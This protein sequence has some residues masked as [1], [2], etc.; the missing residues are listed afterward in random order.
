M[1]A[2]LRNSP[3]FVFA[4]GAPD[5]GRYTTNSAD[6]TSAY[7]GSLSAKPDRQRRWRRSAMRLSS[8]ASAA[9]ALEG[10]GANAQLEVARGGAECDVA[11]AVVLGSLLEVPPVAIPALMAWPPRLAL[12]VPPLVTPGA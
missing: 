1:Q 2:S 5:V 9:A 3:P 10:R 7:A 6:A 4:R 11:P 8:A 12:E